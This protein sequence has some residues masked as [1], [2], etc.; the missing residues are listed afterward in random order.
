MKR[1]SSKKRLQQKMSKYQLRQR[2]N[3]NYYIVDEEGN[4]IFEEYLL[5]ETNTEEEAWKQAKL[6]IQTTQNFN[7][8]HPERVIM[9]HAEE[10]QM[11][12]GKR[13]QGGFRKK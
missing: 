7:R 1:K 9:E 12:I 11:R 3:G 6:T 13:I 10:K 5:P 4:N 8:T 2:K